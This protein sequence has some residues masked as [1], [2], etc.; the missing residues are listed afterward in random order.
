MMWAAKYV[1]LPFLD[2]GRDFK[3]VDCWGLVRLVLK[4]EKGIDVPSYGDISAT[5]LD[6][7][8]RMVKREA[9]LVPWVD[10]LPNAVQPFDVAVMFR[11]IA[12]VHVGIM[13]TRWD[14]LHIEEKISAVM[15]PLTHSSI[16]F[17]YPRFFRHRDL[18]PRF[19]EAS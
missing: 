3:G 17:R 18:L 7:V 13:V 19:V 2:H 5:D 14:V 4:E 9:L 8:A 12:P 1:G 6:A 10:V 15:V 11:R 16:V